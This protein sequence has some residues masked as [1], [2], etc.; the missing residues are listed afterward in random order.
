[1]QSI[2]QTQTIKLNL[3][4]QWTPEPIKEYWH[5][6]MIA[7]LVAV[8]VDSEVV[9]AAVEVVSLPAEMQVMPMRSSCRQ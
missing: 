4:C 9:E 8:E 6:R 2:C 3:R 1:M 5:R 7:V